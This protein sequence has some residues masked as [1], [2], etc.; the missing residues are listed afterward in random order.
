MVGYLPYSCQDVKFQPISSVLLS[1]MMKL[2]TE[3]KDDSRL[4][5]LAYVA[6]GKIVRRAPQLVKKD[7]GLAQ[8]LFDAISNVRGLKYRLFRS[9]VIRKQI[10]QEIFFLIIIIA[11]K[12]SQ[13]ACK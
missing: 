3:T 7:I 1:G 6:V 11:E 10:M 9:F 4:R 13:K 5:S 12:I 8:K 2:I